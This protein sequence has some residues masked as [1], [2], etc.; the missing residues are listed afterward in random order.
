MIGGYSS[1]LS[2][3]HRIGSCGIHLDSVQSIS[4]YR[5][6]GIETEVPVFISELR[7]DTVEELELNALI[8]DVTVLCGIAYQLP[9][10]ALYQYV[11]KRFSIFIISLLIQMIGIRRITYTVQ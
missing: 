4:A 7:T 2:Y 10:P 5:T 1:N 3:N 9:S 11:L 6:V 8:G